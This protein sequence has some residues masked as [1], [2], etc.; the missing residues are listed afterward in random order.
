MAV[1]ALYYSE[2]D[3]LSV[4]IQNPDKLLF[5]TK[6]EADSRDKMLEL[7]EEIRDFL[8]R[9]VAGMD[10]DMA[11]RTSEVIAENKALFQRAFKKPSTLN[12]DA[13]AVSASTDEVTP[14]VRKKPGRKPKEQS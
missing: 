10:E 6:A 4:A 7:A 13:S 8:V 2:K 5:A 12:E 3:G 9:N 1:K 11:D 14:T